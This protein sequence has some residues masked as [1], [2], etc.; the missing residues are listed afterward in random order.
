LIIQNANGT[1]TFL[2]QAGD[3]AADG[4]HGSKFVI[5]SES[6]DPSNLVNLMAFNH[7]VLTFLK[8]D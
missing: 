1:E 2:Q 7:E 6:M 3:P 5:L 4:I 8:G